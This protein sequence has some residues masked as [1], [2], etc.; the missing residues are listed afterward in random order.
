MVHFGLLRDSCTAG[1]AGAAMKTLRRVLSMAAHAV[2]FERAIVTGAGSGIGRATAAALCERGID[3]YGVGRREGALLETKR[4]A[5]DNFH[6]VVADVATPEGRGAIADRIDGTTPTVVVHN[7]A[8]TGPLGPLDALTLDGFRATMAS[9]VEGPLFLTKAL[10]PKLARGSRVLHVSTGGAHQGFDG[11]L[12]Y[13]A[14]KAALRSVYESLR[15]E[16][17]GRVCFGSAQPGVVA[18]EMMRSLVE[19]TDDSFAIRDYFTGLA[20]ATPAGG[21]A[22]AVPVDGLNS[23]E[24]VAR[25]FAFLLFDTNDDEFGE[26]DW[27]IRDEAHHGRWA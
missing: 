17:A 9:N 21:A 1:V 13:C 23:P 12:S 5:G 25:F 20:E 8:T 11:M 6:A 16:H 24:N 26:K 15:D 27:D 4:M 14:S 10:M 22:T 19:D 18:T 7:A 3:V 2:A